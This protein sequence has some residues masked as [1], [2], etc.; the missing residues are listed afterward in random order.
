MKII[1]YSELYENILNI[2]CNLRT[3]G[4]FLLFSLLVSWFY[5]EDEMTVEN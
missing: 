2:L 5:G 4:Y 3:F 1:E